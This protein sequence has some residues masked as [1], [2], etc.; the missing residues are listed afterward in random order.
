MHKNLISNGN[1][2]LEQ[3]ED[4]VRL[5]I[6]TALGRGIPVIPVRIKGANLPTEG[7][8]PESIKRMFEKL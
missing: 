3:L 7:E 8:L 4:W 2:R 1:R 6:E 5:E